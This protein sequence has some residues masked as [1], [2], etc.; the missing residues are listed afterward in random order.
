MSKL[1]L[2]FSGSLATTTVFYGMMHVYYTQ[3]AIQIEQDLFEKADKL[4][5]EEK[6][7]IKESLKN[8]EIWKNSTIV[9][10]IT[11]TPKVTYVA[12]ND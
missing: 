11:N 5:L 2:F 7:K 9:E 8:I 4:S 12:S 1:L 6:L 3:K 10:Q